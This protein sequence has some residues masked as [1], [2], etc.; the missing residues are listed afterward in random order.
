MGKIDSLPD[1]LQTDFHLDQQH[2]GPL[3]CLLS[4]HDIVAG[5][6]P[7][8]ARYDDNTILT[9]RLDQREGYARA[10][11][12]VDYHPAG[13]NTFTSKYLLK[14]LTK[15]ISAQSAQHTHRRSSSSSSRGGYSLITPLAADKHPESAAY[16]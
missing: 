12:M 1:R 11:L 4:G 14:L 7:I 8:G 13:T 16:Q 9:V 15:D 6:T 2:S 3:E 10:L 5:N